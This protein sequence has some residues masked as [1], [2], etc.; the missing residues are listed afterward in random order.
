MF[1]PSPPGSSAGGHG[2]LNGD[3]L[4]GPSRKKMRKG[5]KSCIECRR[6]KIRCTFE[7]GRPVV[8]NECYARGSTC[9][10][11]EHGDVQ[12]FNPSAT[13]EQAYSL[14]ER[15]TQLEGM[16]KEV[17]NRLPE[18]NGGT[19]NSMR[20]SVGETQAAAEV[21]KNLRTSALVPPV[22]SALKTPG[23][24]QENAPVLSLFD[25]AVLSTHRDDP[26][27]AS[28]PQNGK[29][30]AL[31]K[32]LTSLLPSPTDL[33]TLL[34]AS[35][36]W[37][38]IWRKMFPEICD[39]ACKT[40]KESVSHSLRSES[41]AE[42]AKMLLCLAISIDQIPQAFD[43]STLKLALPPR[44]LMERYINTVDKLITSDDEIASTVDGIECLV[45]QAKY[46]INLGRPRRAW[47]LFRRATSFAQL[48]GLHRTVNRTKDVDTSFKR[49]ESLWC[50]L[51]Q[52]D[53]YLSLILGLPYSISDDFCT[54]NLINRANKDLPSGELYLLRMA[55]I[56]S[57]I[58]DRNQDEGNLPYAATLQIDQDLEE[59]SHSMSPEWW[60]IDW[61]TAKDSPID[62]YDRAVAQFFHHQVR[63]LLHLP[64]MLKSSADKR[65]QYS[66]LAALES[67]REIIRCYKALRADGGVGPYICK[68]IDFQAFTAA[69]LLLLNILGYSQSSI[70]QDIAQEERDSKLVD[71]TIAIL[72]H[73]STEPSGIIAAQSAKA[74]ELIGLGRHF[75]CEGGK[76]GDSCRISIPY[77]GTITI[78]AGKSFKPG[79][80]PPAQAAPNV[81]N[82][83]QIPTPPDSIGGNGGNGLVVP[84]Q[85]QTV[86]ADDPFISFDSYTTMPMNDQG[87][88]GVPNY[89]NDP[90]TGMWPVMNNFDLDQ[91][92]NWFSNEVNMP[93]Q[94]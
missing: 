8:C 32:A 31:V 17:L 90:N 27:Q 38:T 18:N 42:V 51:F 37:W 65:F 30:K 78:G 77:F 25:N 9:I 92:W 75:R 39:P 84:D 64:F 12:S 21:L 14:R 16:V 93:Q 81:V 76:E 15:V 1:S 60:T 35:A 34:D 19:G 52:G 58:V 49:Q 71:E 6:R 5:T 10:D 33:E 69:M 87:L 26:V 59:V 13:G 55:P 80:P 4:Q 28:F 29:S 54:P 40:L 22:E 62:L 47:L 85:S 45:L 46:H 89:M 83:F 57:R 63:T 86:F 66:Q 48:I 36:D 3:H 56:I 91:S 61:T 68:L 50:H 53:R 72:H 24:L 82:P 7:E 44:E 73:A 74:L 88:T 70:H 2:S 11:Q 23:G 43:L 20:G 79:G 67:S 41:P 94:N